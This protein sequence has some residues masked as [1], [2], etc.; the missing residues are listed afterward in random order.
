MKQTKD[1]VSKNN[2][3][4]GAVAAATIGFEPRP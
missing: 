2:T 1:S 3:A 4:L